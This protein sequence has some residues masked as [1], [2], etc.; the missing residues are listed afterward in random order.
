MMAVVW[1]DIAKWWRW[2]RELASLQ[3]AEQRAYVAWRRADY[4]YHDTATVFRD[5]SGFWGELGRA[6]DAC[7]DRYEE[8]SQIKSK[9]R[10]MQA[11]GP[12]ALVR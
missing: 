2:R 12:D 6:Q 1:T 9:I 10:R 5:S 11:L 7:A 4:V 8:F 3:R